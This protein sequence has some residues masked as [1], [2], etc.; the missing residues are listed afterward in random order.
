[1]FEVEF[2]PRSKKA[3]TNE[4]IKKDAIKQG[5]SERKSPAQ[6][7]SVEE[8]VYK[9]DIEKAL[10]ISLSNPMSS[11]EEQ[12]DDDVVKAKTKKSPTEEDSDYEPE[13][14][15]VYESEDDNDDEEKENDSDFSEEEVR[16]KTV[17]KEKKTKSKQSFSDSKESVTGNKKQTSVVKETEKQLPSEISASRTKTTTTNPKPGG[18][19]KKP[20]T[21]TSLGSPA[22][23]KD[24]R[25]F[26]LGGVIIKNPGPP[27]RVGLSRNMKVKPLHSKVSVSH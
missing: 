8:K 11:N 17:S 6:R 21:T 7:L 13:Q 4:V 23:N 27:I 19:G 16:R 10:E 2:E 25:S 12:D 1:D 18:L 9:R 5:K 15:T 3:K 26:G 14:E 24:L 20:S 22:V